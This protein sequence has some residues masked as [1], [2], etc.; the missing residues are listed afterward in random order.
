MKKS[1]IT[2]HVVALMEKELEW[3]HVVQIRTV[4]AHTVCQTQLPCK[5]ECRQEF[6]VGAVVLLIP[7]D[8]V[9]CIDAWGIGF[10]FEPRTF[11]TKAC[12][13]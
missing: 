5:M 12:L 6:I 7:D 9:G 13:G 11:Q 8:V 4:D 3:I 10:T 1:R 2:L